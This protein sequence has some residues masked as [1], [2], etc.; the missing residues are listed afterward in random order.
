MSLLGET[1]KWHHIVI[2]SHPLR[3]LL[4]CTHSG[5]QARPGN[6]TG[7]MLSG[8]YKPTLQ[9]DK[10]NIFDQR[11]NQM[12]LIG[13]G[14]YQRYRIPV[15]KPWERKRRDRKVII[16]KLDIPKYSTTKSIFVTTKPLDEDYLQEK[17]ALSRKSY[18]IVT[19]SS[20]NFLKNNSSNKNNSFS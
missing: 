15:R 11:V 6:P 17:V 12:K 20:L 8:F 19:N 7:N 1:Q 9:Y 2:N 14:L 4:P 18:T 16:Y 13:C 10:I 5:C 3:S